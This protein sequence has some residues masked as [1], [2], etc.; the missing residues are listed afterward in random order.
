MNELNTV[1][2]MWLRQVKRYVRSKSRIVGSLGMP[3]LFLVALGFGFGP[4]FAKAGGGNYIQFLAPGIMGMS[5]LFMSVFNGLELIWDRQFGFLKETLVAPVSR[6]AIVFGRTL[7]GATVSTLQGI[8]VLIISLFIGFQVHNLLFIPLA[9]AF[10]FL[11]S[12]LFNSLGTI[13]A[14]KLE[15]T[16]AFQLIVNFVIMPI[17]FLSGALFPI[18]ELPSSLGFVTK[19]NPL[20]YGVDSLRYLLTGFSELGIILDFIVLI[21]GIII[22]SLIGGYLFSTIE[23]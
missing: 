14:S 4:I 7:G 19:L 8:I 2:I 3:I 21:G 6:N 10:M 23:P 13:I 20:S 18:R 22:L 16:Q 9:I 12:F 1:Y 11:I 15:D 5:I 17:F